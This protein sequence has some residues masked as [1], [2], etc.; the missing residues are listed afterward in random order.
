MKQMHQ[1]NGGVSVANYV[2][3]INVFVTDSAHNMQGGGPRGFGFGI[4]QGI[5]GGLGHSTMQ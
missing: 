5:A 3:N 2:Q 4:G 1:P